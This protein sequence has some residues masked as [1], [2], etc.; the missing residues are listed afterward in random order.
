MKWR[1]ERMADGRRMYA[2]YPTEE[3]LYTVFRID[4]KEWPADPSGWV[5]SL[6]HPSPHKKDNRIRRFVAL[7]IST[8]EEAKAEAEKDW[9]TRGLWDFVPTRGNPDYG[10]LPWPWEETE[11]V[12]GAPSWAWWPMGRRW[13]WDSGDQRQHRG[14]PPCYRLVASFGM[15]A[16]VK[17]TLWYIA[18]WRGREFLASGRDLKV[19]AKTAEGDWALRQM[20]PAHENPPRL[21]RAPSPWE[22]HFYSTEE[23][24]SKRA[25]R[26]TWSVR[27]SGHTH[28]HYTMTQPQKG[29][30]ALWWMGSRWSPRKSDIEL[31]GEFSS[32]NEAAQVAERDW[33]LRQFGLAEANSTRKKRRKH[34]ARTYKPFPYP[35]VK[36]TS[37]DPKRIVE[38]WDLIA[39]ENDFRGRNTA[40][41]RAVVKAADGRIHLFLHEIDNPEAYY[42]YYN[43]TY[44]GTYD[45]PDEVHSAV[46]ADWALRH[47]MPGSER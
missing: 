19:L 10:T 40:I 16:A 47:F 14:P 20:G 32:V 46:E 7:G 31:L 45:D 5:V 43:K 13:A 22:G 39:G 24:I 41:Y 26:W 12:Q 30:Y 44:I 23:K 15:D 42:A 38:T 8:A 18:G 21:F 34:R 27:R 33:S 3:H 29:R 36:R 11:R 17:Y 6:W 4:E 2:W 37:K 28:Y 1:K 9:E 25:K 35:W